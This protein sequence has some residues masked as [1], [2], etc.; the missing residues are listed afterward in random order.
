MN[1]I[2]RSVNNTQSALHTLYLIRGMS[3]HLISKKGTIRRVHQPLCQP[4]LPLA[5]GS[6][7]TDKVD[8]RWQRQTHKA[9][10]KPFFV[11][12]TTSSSVIRNVN[13]LPFYSGRQPICLNSDVGIRPT[14]VA[15]FALR[16]PPRAIAPLHITQLRAM[17]DM[18]T[19]YFSA[20]ARISVRS[21]SISSH[22][23]LLLLNLR[24]HQHIRRPNDG[25]TYTLP[26]GIG[27]LFEYFPVNRPIAR[28]ESERSNQFQSSR[29]SMNCAQA[30][31]AILR[32]CISASSPD[33]SGN[34]RRR[35]YS[36]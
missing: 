25:N 4:Q 36:T 1:T 18:V 35:L 5:H 26:D 23:T 6:A 21:G 24:P 8:D 31:R 2:R 14:S 9:P 33:C 34:C 15:C 7:S 11:S 27:L 30:R 10:L 32:F 19:S 29:I 12:D 16:A 22:D 20:K 28:G 13:A 3:R 17:A